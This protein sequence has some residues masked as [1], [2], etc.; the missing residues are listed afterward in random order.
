MLYFEFLTAVGQKGNYRFSPT[1]SITNFYYCVNARFTFNT[2]LDDYSIVLLV[3][4]WTCVVVVVHILDG[5]LCL[6]YT[7][8]KEC[9]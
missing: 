7:S 8:S 3:E 2:E 9:T 5:T 1:N 6:L 4:S